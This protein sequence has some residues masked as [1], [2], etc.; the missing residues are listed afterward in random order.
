MNARIDAHQHFWRYSPAAPGWIDETMAVLKRDFLPDDLWPLLDAEGFA[1]SIAVQARTDVSEAEWLLSLAAEH[2]F[3]RGVVGWVDLT[4][5]GVER[6]LERLAAHPRFVGVR[7]VVQ[8]EPGGFMARVDFR[9]GIAA[10]DRF[11]L[12][13]DVLVYA[14]QLTEAVALVRAFPRQRFVVDHI[15]KPDIKNKSFDAWARGMR[16]LAASENTW[17]KLSGLVTEADWASWSPPDFW[18][19][20]D[21]VLEA[22][23]PARCMIGSD[24]PVCTLAGTYRSVIAIV[25]DYIAVLSPD[26]QAAIH[27]GT[28]A[29]FY[30][31]R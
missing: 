11:G 22:F 9:R 27:G 3:I 15:A 7:H 17:C 2:G 6:E 20:L 19:Y 16:E 29:A 23:G 5:L 24:W 1:G 28:A 25:R 31:L 26:E 18:P 21:V 10:L 13:Y 12:A 30:G 8:S 4:S 14:R